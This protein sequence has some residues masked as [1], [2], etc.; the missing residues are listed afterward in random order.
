MAQFP[1]QQAKI[2]QHSI[3]QM[4]T[5]FNTTQLQRKKAEY[6][7]ISVKCAAPGLSS[8]PRKIVG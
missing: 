5:Y 4:I 7:Y 6:A 8:C 3:T 1:I 2:N